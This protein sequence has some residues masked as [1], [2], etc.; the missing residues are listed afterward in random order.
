MSVRAYRDIHRRK[1][2][3]IMVGKVPVGGDAPITVQ[4]MTNTLTCDAK[5]TIAQIKLSELAG[6]DVVRVSCPDEDSTAAL[7]EIVRGVS[8]TSSGHLLV[9]MMG[10]ALIGSDAAMADGRHALEKLLLRFWAFLDGSTQEL[11]DPYYLSITLSAQKMF[12]DY[13]PQPADR[14]MG[15]ILV[16]RTMELLV[17]VYHS[18]TR[19]LIAASNRARMS[20]IFVEQDGIYGVLHTASREGAVKYLDQAAPGKVFGMPAWGY[21][22]PPGRVAVQSLTAPWAPSWLSGLIDDKPVPF[23]ETATNT[24]RNNFRPPMWRRTYL[25]RWHGLASADIRGGTAD[26]IAQWVRKPE[27][28]TRLED[29][30]TLTVRYVANTPNL[31]TT[32]DGVIPQPGLTLTYQ[33]RNRAIVFAKPHGN[34]DR[35]LEAAGKDVSSLATVIG[36]WDFSARTG[37]E[38]FVDDQK[39]ESYPLRARTAPKR[40]LVRDGV[41]YLAILPLPSTDLERDIALQWLGWAALALALIAP[42]FLRLLTTEPY[43]GA[44]AAMLVNLSR[45]LRWRR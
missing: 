42:W 12:A 8:A 21:D 28:S 34:R 27:K 43:W 4:T 20:G 6:V 36:L 45:R 16:D 41:T 15:R 30:G 38:I 33:S 44:T 7:K 18:Q 23:E 37:L 13:G 25:G 40:I 32:A 29:L 24:T 9:P 2:R 1:S 31:V 39:L 35:F 26:V 14:L 17:S 5:A 3:Q 22:F 10:G 19:R 11:L